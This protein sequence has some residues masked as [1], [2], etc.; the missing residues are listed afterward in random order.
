[1]FSSGGQEPIDPTTGTSLSLD[2]LQ[3][4][5]ELYYSGALYVSSSFGGAQQQE[6]VNIETLLQR[7]FGSDRDCWK[8]GLLLLTSSVGSTSS[9]MQHVQWFALTLLEESVHHVVYW[10]NQMKNEERQEVENF[11]MTQLLPNFRVSF[12]DYVML[13]CNSA[14]SNS[15]MEEGL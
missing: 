6:Q 13:T 2:K 9:S 5:L 12:F 3:S 1:M 11:L 14:F 7:Y 4:L 8:K 10:E 15:H